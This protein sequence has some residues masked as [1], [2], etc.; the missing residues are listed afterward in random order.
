MSTSP[1]PRL[2]DQSGFTLS[3]VL[4]SLTLGAI[5]TG[6]AVLN[7]NGARA[8]LAISGA[9][10]ALGSLAARARAHAVERGAVVRL[11][12][13]PQADSI[14]VSLGGDLV[15]GQGLRSEFGVDVSVEGG[16]FHLCFTPRG[17]ADPACSSSP[18]ARVVQFSRASRTEEA[19]ILPLGQVE[20]R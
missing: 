5:L 14:W 9:E 8:G 15:A 10:R 12:V 6:M 20:Y 19:T 7:P 17:F 18:Q 13:D 16:G 4:V 2:R 1:P 3:E 11:N